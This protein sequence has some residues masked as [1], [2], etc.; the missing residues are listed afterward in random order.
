MVVRRLYIIVL[1]ALAGLTHRGCTELGEGI[2]V[3]PD[4]W[5]IEHLT[6][7]RTAGYDLTFCESCHGDDLAGKGETPADKTLLSRNS[8]GHGAASSAILRVDLDHEVVIAQVR[9][10]AGPK[11]QE[12]FIRFLK[13]IEDG[14]MED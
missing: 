2:K 9:N 4:N 5:S 12:Y 3:H 6:K 11:Y 7:V 8:I 13:A 10:T 1:V 14:I